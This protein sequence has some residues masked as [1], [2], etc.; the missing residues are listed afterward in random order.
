MSPYP[1]PSVVV[2][3]EGCSMLLQFHLLEKDSPL[4]SRFPQPCS[5]CGKL[6][7]GASRC[8]VH[9]R[10]YQASRNRS[11]GERASGSEARRARKSELYNY[12]YRQ[13]AKRIRDTATH[14]HI[15]KQP[16]VQGDKIEADHL[17]AGVAGSPLAPAHRRCN[18]SRG[19]RPLW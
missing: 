19:N 18:Q 12:A 9:E 17:I 4:M 15:C 3:P 5:V 6:T 16:F 2:A 14:C 13:E 7:G 11:R 10:E 8:S 1:A